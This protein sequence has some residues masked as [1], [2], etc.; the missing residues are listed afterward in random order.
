MTTASILLFSIP[1]L[2]MH[3][4]KAEFTYSCREEAF[5]LRVNA[6]EFGDV[7]LLIANDLRLR[8]TDQ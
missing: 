5:L 2:Y 8:C 6:I 1:V 4:C 3:S 7:G